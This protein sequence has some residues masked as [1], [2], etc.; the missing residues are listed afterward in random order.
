MDKA[1]LVDIRGNGVIEFEALVPT[2]R[3]QLVIPIIQLI[4]FLAQLVDGGKQTILLQSI[5]TEDS[6]ICSVVDLGDVG[7][8]CIQ[9][10]HVQVSNAGREL[11]LQLEKQSATK[12]MA[13][14]VQSFPVLT[15]GVDVVVSNE[16]LLG[17]Q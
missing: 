12:G 3:G 6:S 1:I 5:A 17:S 13:N 15:D 9:Q 7:S 10:L 16:D 4:L 11:P 2:H 8:T 14:I